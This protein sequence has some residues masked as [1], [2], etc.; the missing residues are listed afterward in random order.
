MQYRKFGNSNTMISALGFGTMHLPTRKDHSYDV[1]ESI[2]MLHK[3]FELGVNY[4]DTATLYCNNQSEIIV[5]KA[6]KGWRDKIMLS[7]KYQLESISP[8]DLRMRLEISL[9]NLSTDSIDY[10]HLWAANWD[11]FQKIITT[12]TLKELE[13]IKDEGLIKNLSFSFHDKP[14]NMAKII[15][16]YGGFSSVLCQYNLLDRSNEDA[17]YNARDKGLG[18]AIMGPIGGGKLGY[19]S[20]AIQSLLLGK[21]ASSPEIAL[22][23]VLSHPAVS[24]A[25]SGMSDMKH[26]EENVRVASNTEPLSEAELKQ[27]MVSLEENKKRADLYCTGCNYCMPCPQGVGIPQIFEMMN[28]HRVY[29]LTEY[30]RN[31]YKQI[32]EEW[33]N[34][35]KVSDCI[36]CGQC[37]TKCP[38][39]IEIRRQLHESEKILA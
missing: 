10:Y 20:N 5:G 29:N 25:L 38:Q 7:T 26:V 8:E 37:E 28:Y 4:V 11:N 21:S 13:K 17:I 31:E 34:Y 33:A 12:K 19:P 30:A 39:K 18:V 27:I 36:D 16:A 2:R 14:E 6:L 32:G 15:D 3:A 22:R 9:K 35:G 1:D 23:F 24:C